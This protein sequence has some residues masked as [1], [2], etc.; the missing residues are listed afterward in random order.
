[1]QVVSAMLR[2]QAEAVHSHHG[3]DTSAILQ[4]QAVVHGR[5]LGTAAASA[6]LRRQAVVHD[7][8]L[9]TAAPQ[10]PF[11]FPPRG[12]GTD[13]ATTNPGGVSGCRWRSRVAFDRPLDVAPCGGLHGVSALRLFDVPCSLVLEHAL[14]S[15]SRSAGL[16]G[17]GS[18]SDAGS[19]NCAGSG[20]DDNDASAGAGND[21]GAGSND[22]PL[23]ATTDT[24][25]VSQS[26]AVHRDPVDRHE[27]FEAALYVA[28]LGVSSLTFVGLVTAES[29]CGD[30]PRVSHPLAPGAVVASVARTFV[31]VQRPGAGSAPRGLPFTD[32]ERRRLGPAALGTTVGDGG[33]VIGGG[34]TS[35]HAVEVAAAIAAAVA[36]HS[37]ATR[38]PRP[39][40]GVGSGSSGSSGSSSS[41]GGGSSARS[42]N[43]SSSSGSGS[44]IARSGSSRSGAAS[45]GAEETWLVFE[46]LVLPHHVN[47]GRHVDHG[48]LLSWAHDAA[49]LARA[50]RSSSSSSIPSAD[51]AGGGTAR[52]TARAGAVRYLAAGTGGA[53]VAC[54]AGAGG[55]SSSVRSCAAV[56][57]GAERGAPGPVLCEATWV[58][59]DYR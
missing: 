2:R 11:F 12:D 32:E 26:F 36:R 57:A 46:Q 13:D 20:H 23:S 19:G 17:R 34:V 43:S 54:S 39:G 30:N 10:Q 28:S 47:R 8:G 18:P 41:G 59:E 52:G 37:A 25:C 33:G 6:M 27:A 45:G 53:V 29:S 5:G 44:G 3:L 24:F 21:R 42:S 9:G 58:W 40:S 16:S 14:L 35:A 1:M 50:R 38:S 56:D 4:R 22:E 51:G 48:C 31:R 7:R 55:A 15:G 49:L